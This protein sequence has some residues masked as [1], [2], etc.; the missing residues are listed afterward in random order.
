MKVFC[1]CQCGPSLNPAWLDVSFATCPAS[2]EVAS[3]QPVAPLTDRW[4]SLARV[5]ELHVRLPEYVPFLRAQI[6]RP[7]WKAIYLRARLHAPVRL[8]L[9]VAW[10]NCFAA[11]QVFGCHENCIAHLHPTLIATARRQFCRPHIDQVCSK[12]KDCDSATGENRLG[13]CAQF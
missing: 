4:Q 6:R 5:N 12:E 11:S 1:H 10:Q 9:L 2:A 7:G 13:S 3:P 8:V